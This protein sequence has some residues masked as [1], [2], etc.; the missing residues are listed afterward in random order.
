MGTSFQTNQSVIKYVIVY[1]AKWTLML[2]C[3][4]AMSA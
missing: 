2:C 1:L 3:P 4:V